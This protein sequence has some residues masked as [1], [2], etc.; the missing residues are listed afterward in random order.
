MAE[1]AKRATNKG[2]RILFVVHRKEIVDQVVR[3]FKQ[4]GVDMSLS[5]I[6]MV[7][8]ITRRVDKLKE[9]SIIF[10]DEAH[11]VLAKSYRRILDKFPN[12]LK[13]LF[14]ATP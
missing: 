5:K 13:L 6:G 12:A 10:V 8:T 14:T 1:I 11:H 7:Q 3:T 2:N 9:P 4:Q